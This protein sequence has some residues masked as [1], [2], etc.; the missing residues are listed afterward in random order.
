MVF[1]VRAHYPNH[2]SI[3]WEKILIKKISGNRAIFSQVNIWKGTSGPG[4]RSQQKIF[5]FCLYII[6]V[7]RTCSCNW[8]LIEERYNVSHLLSCSHGKHIYSFPISS[9]SSSRDECRMLTWTCWLTLTTIDFE[10]KRSD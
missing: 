2:L 1:E 7:D 4:V 9:L 8:T 5:L 10:I 6:C 3:Y